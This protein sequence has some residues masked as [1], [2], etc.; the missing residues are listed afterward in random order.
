M[1]QVFLRVAW[2]VRIVFRVCCF[3]SQRSSAESGACVCGRWVSEFGGRSWAKMMFVCFRAVLCRDPP[4]SPS[5]LRGAS[6]ASWAVS[7]SAPLGPLGVV[8]RG[9]GCGPD[10]RLL[11][12]PL[13]F[14]LV[15]P[16]PCDDG[17]VHEVVRCL[18]YFSDICLLGYLS[19]RWFS[20]AMGLLSCVDGGVHEVVRRLADSPDVRPLVVPSAEVRRSGLP[21][22]WCTALPVRAPASRGQS[23]ADVAELRVELGYPVGRLARCRW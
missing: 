8:D 17:G 6:W 9:V 4:L 3:V 22:C 11:H 2:L 14:L 21:W 15:A 10:V 18:S 23:V 7:F 5:L 13:V 19:P 12:G 16:F 20:G 1:R